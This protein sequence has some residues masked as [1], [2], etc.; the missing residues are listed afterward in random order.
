[1]ISA[2][3]AAVRPQLPASAD[4]ED[5]AIE[6]RKLKGFTLGSEGLIADWYWMTSLQYMGKKIEADTGEFTNL[7]DLRSLD[8]RLLYPYLDNATDLDPKFMAAYS[9]GATVL[10]AIDPQQA[11]ALTEKGIAN[12]PDQWRL[13]QYLGY[14]YWRLKDLDKAGHVYD[15]G[16]AI[17][18]SP[19]VMR[20]MSAA[21]RTKSNDRQTARAIYQQ[22]YDSGDRETQYNANVRLMELDS[23]D[24]RDVIDP[25]LKSYQERAGK[26]PGSFSEVIPTLK[27]VGKKDLRINDKN[28]LVDPAGYPYRIDSS[29]CK[30]LVALDSPIPKQ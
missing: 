7:E 1:M 11:I 22:M 28:E 9:Y 10:P 14:I 13:Y 26:C 15:K 21:M 8:P 29:D 2:N 6:G 19:V 4:N 24:E 20:M 27:T 17:P 5:L 16:S 25:A 30:A 18:G 3:A 23:L 12:N